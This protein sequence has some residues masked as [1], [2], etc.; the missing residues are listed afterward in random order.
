MITT[1]LN[2]I[3]EHDPCKAGWKKLL[4]GLGKTADDDDDDHHRAARQRQTE[5]FAE[6]VS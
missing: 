4:A 2:R 5:I 6:I 1:T 3:R